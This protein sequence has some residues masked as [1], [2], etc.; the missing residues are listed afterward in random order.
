MVLVPLVHATL[1][2]GGLAE[3]AEY[4]CCVM[5]RLSVSLC[6]ASVTESSGMD[7][8]VVTLSVEKDDSVKYQ[9]KKNS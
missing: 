8:L 4:L 3:A 6:S 5:V 9:N 7:G 2:C 1:G